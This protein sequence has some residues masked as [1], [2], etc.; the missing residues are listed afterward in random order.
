MKTFLVIIGSLLALAL[1]GFFILGLTLGS[2]VKRE[3]NTYGPQYT[4]TTVQVDSVRLSPLSGGGSVE[5]LVIGNPPGWQS[6]HS[7]SLGKIALELKATSLLSDH[8]II[9]SLAIDSPDIVYETKYT[10]SNLQ[11]LLKN[12]QKDDTA[13]EANRAPDKKPPPKIEIKVLQLTN[14]KITVIASGHTQVVTIP[15]IRMENVGTSDGGLTP[16]QLSV[17]VLKEITRQSL[18]A[19]AKDFFNSTSLDKVANKAADALKRLLQP[20]ST[21]AE[22]TPAP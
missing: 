9:D 15:S 14:A 21:Q 2:I 17:A 3:I 22:P 12:I 20:D 19:A 6:D 10:S 7:F 5:H 11:D 4:Q 13:K 8:V 1:I 16:G 18:Q